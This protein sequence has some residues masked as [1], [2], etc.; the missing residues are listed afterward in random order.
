MRL[1]RAFPKGMD[2]NSRWRQPMEGARDGK[3]PQRGRTRSGVTV[4]RPRLGRGVIYLTFP[5]G[6]THGYSRFPLAGN[7]PCAF[8]KGMDV[9]S[10]RRQ[11]MEGACGG[12]RPQRGRTRLEVAIVRPRWGRGVIHPAFP[13]GF[14]HGYSRFPLAGNP[15]CAFPKGMDVNSRWRQPTE[16]ASGGERP[17]RGR[18][19]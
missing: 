4:V 2:V 5:V 18:T 9:N 3:R 11:A 17:Q 8:P 12:K 19:I 1:R 6:F 15:P 10:R 7:P 16:G 14:T 13:V